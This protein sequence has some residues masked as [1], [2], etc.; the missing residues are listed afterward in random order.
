MVEDF[1]FQDANQ[2]GSFIGLPAEFFLRP[3]RREQG[4]LDQV[5]RDF[6]LSDPRERK[7]VEDVAMRI[8]PMGR[9]GGSAILHGAI[10]SIASGFPAEQEIFALRCQVFGLFATDWGMLTSH[11]AAR[12]EGT[13]YF[14]RLAA[15]GEDVAAAQRL[16]YE[17]FNLELREGLAT[18]HGAGLDR[19]DFDEVMDHLVVIERTTARV[20]GTYRM[21]TGTVA[22]LRRGYYSEREF[23]FLPFEPLRP[24]IVELGRACVHRDHRT[25]S[26]VSLLWREILRYALA[27]GARY[28]VGCSSLTSQDSDTGHAMFRRLAAG[29][30]AP[31]RLQT[32]PRSG[33]A[34]PA[35]GSLPECG[36]PPRLLRAYLALGAWICG[37]P[38]LDREF[39]TIDFLTLLDCSQVSDGVWERFLIRT[40]GHDA[41]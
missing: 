41:E 26:V 11:S 29:G 18:S 38:A 37:P 19:D 24:Q 10:R 20:V 39:G 3:N 1:V 7:A 15:S 4:F 23:E 8:D 12:A 34:L 33:Y 31:S 40:N 17:V 5:F 28:L 16:R 21:Q 9:V 13:G 36:E 35:A 2:P 25:L 6:G 27:R 30:L 22:A 14:C 32:R